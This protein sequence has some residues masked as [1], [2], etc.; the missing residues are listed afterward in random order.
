MVAADVRAWTFDK[1]KGEDEIKVDGKKVKEHEGEA[2]LRLPKHKLYVC[3]HDHDNALRGR[4]A[5]NWG[6]EALGL[7][8]LENKHIKT[9][10]DD[11][12]LSGKFRNSKGELNN[13]D[14]TDWNDETYGKGNGH[15]YQA[16]P[17]A[18]KYYLDQMKANCD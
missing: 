5:F 10:I 7:H 9:L 16:V 3:W 4:P 6:R 13:R 2:I 8:G 17:K 18:L 11:P 12:D 14:C 1:K 15:G